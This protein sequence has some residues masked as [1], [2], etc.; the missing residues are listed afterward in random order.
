MLAP[1]QQHPQQ[2]Q[3]HMQQRQ[4]HM[5]AGMRALC[6]YLPCLLAPSVSCHDHIWHPVLLPRPPHPTHPTHPHPTP[7][8]PLTLQEYAPLEEEK[9]AERR[10]R[11][12]IVSEADK[13][14]EEGE[15][16]KAR[17]DRFGLMSD[18]ER[19]AKGEG[20]T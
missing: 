9:K 17:K 5:H 4:R 16:L 15:R 14:V 2:R 19:V 7:L 8:H 1:H 18:K 20:G 13:K 12:G 3:R 6:T 11:F 10:K